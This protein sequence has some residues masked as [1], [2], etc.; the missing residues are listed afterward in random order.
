MV[1]N[2]KGDPKAKYQMYID[3]GLCTQEEADR[4]VKEA[5][6]PKHKP[7]LDTECPGWWD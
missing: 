1:D 7:T 3:H 5:R 2:I 6:K 4:L